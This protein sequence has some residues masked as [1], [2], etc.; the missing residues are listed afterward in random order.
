MSG[1]G[2][3]RYEE[4][5]HADPY[6]IVEWQDSETSARGWLVIN[7][8]TGGAAGGGTRMKSYATPE[9]GRE[10][11]IF[12]AKT[13]E[14]KFQVSGPR[15]GGAKSVLSFGPRSPE[16]KQGVLRRWFRHI[17]PS[18]KE[19]Y[20]TG[21]DQGVSEGEVIKLT[22]QA[23]DLAH[24]QE[25]IVRGHF[26]LPPEGHQRILQQLKEGV[27]H[28]VEL[29]VAN[30]EAT[31]A[32]V[33]T[34]FGVATSL[35]AL[36]QQK[37]GSLEG[38]RVLVEGFG[39]VGGSTAY[40]LQ[41]K[42]ARVVG[43]LCLIPGTRTFRWLT[44]PA[45][46]DIRSLLSGR[47]WSTQTILTQGDEAADPAAFWRTEADVFVP[48]ATSQTIDA[49]RIELLQKTGIQVIGCGANTPFADRTRGETTVQK[50]ADRAFTVIPDFIA[51]CGMA[52]TFAYLM[53]DG[54]DVSDAAIK[55]DVERIIHGAME[56]LLSGLAG[57]HGLLDRA[58]SLYIPA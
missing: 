42:G 22:E 28:T 2:Y 54:A 41:E 40:Y 3:R 32:D 50:Q 35:E 26:G 5:F 30:S 25:G 20:G 19:R 47:D 1:D 13:M 4:F 52:R 38:K 48:A 31:V 45:G 6:E 46:L 8:L 16:E 18:L 10:D 44:D 12:L 58:F 36:Y 37:G 9:L 49:T 27:K 29:T 11:A 14:I 57:D 15:I 21:G 23:I 43:V 56:R 24:P 17:G 55:E 51:N 39:A 34:G 7:S 33:I 53:Q